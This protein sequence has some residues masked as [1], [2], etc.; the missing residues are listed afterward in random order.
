MW[1]FTEAAGSAAEQF[2]LPVFCF[3]TVNKRAFLVQLHLQK[4]RV[5]LQTDGGFCGGCV[6][7]WGQLRWEAWADTVAALLQQRGG[8]PCF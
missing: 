8:Q 3:Q 1:G 2:E 4:R 5:L 7:A 6:D